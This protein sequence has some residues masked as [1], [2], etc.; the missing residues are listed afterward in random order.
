MLGAYKELIANQFEAAFC[1]LAAC[2]DQCPEE[3]WNRPVG[4]LK[5]CQ[6]AFHALF[7]ADLYLGKDL[8]SLRDQAFHRQYAQAFADYEELENRVQVA[9]YDKAFIKA[10]LRHCRDKAAN[11]IAAET[12]QVLNSRPGFE[13]LKFSRAELHFYNIRHVQHHAAQLSLRLRIDSGV[14]IPWVGSGWRQL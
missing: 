7:F 10:Y 1:T 2:V 4:N 13:R 5:F 3:S 11:V 9:V 14:E 12:E 6:V 8:Q